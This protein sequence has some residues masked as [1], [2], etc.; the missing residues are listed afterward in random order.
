MAAILIDRIRTALCSGQSAGLPALLE[1]ADAAVTAAKALDTASWKRALDPLLSDE[2]I[3]AARKAGEDAAFEAERMA[4]AAKLLRAAL[5]RFRAD[6]EQDRRQAVYDDAIAKRDAAAE[7][8]KAYPELANAIG[9]ILEEVVAADNAVLMARSQMPNGVAGIA[10]VDTVARGRP[11]NSL[12]MQLANIKLPA[13]R[14]G[15][16]DIWGRNQIGT[17]LVPV[18]NPEPTDADEAGHYAASDRAGERGASGSARSSVRLVP[19][20]TGEAA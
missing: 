2:E 12:T 15:A 3:A 4:E 16:P 14:H 1:E 17:A 13:L 19:R 6:E 20:S 9:A 5:D 11:S 18:F 7:K 8:L 10:D